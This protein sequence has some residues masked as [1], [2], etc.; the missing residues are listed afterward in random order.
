VKAA[1]TVPIRL[2]EDAEDLEPTNDMLDW[3]PD[4]CELP[5]AGSLLVGE[6]V[7]LAGLL[8]GPHERMLVL[9]ALIAGIGDEFGLGV[10]GG[11]RL[12]QESKIIRCATTRGGTD[13]L[14]SD[15]MDQQL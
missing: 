8:R 4:P 9:D 15:R 1:P 14:R 7:M 13:D 6:R 3:Q 2:L 12:P 10:N 5:V 11:L